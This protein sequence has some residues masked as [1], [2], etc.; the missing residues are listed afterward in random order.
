MAF[1]GTELSESATRKPAASTRAKSSGHIP[2]HAMKQLGCKACP[3]DKN[4]DKRTPKLDATGPRSTD[5]LVLWGQPSEA[6]DRNGDFGNGKAADAVI[7]Y[8][9][10]AGITKLRHFGTVRCRIPDGD[11]PGVQ[12][13]ECCRGY[14]IREIESSKPRVIVGVGDEALNWAIKFPKGNQTAPTFR[15]RAFPIKVGSH[16]CWFFVMEFPRY[17]HKKSSWKS[18]HE[19]ATEHDARAVR[20]LLDGDTLSVVHTGGYDKGIDIITGSDAGDMVRLEDALNWAIQQ[21]RVG[22]DYETNGLRP[23]YLKEPHIWTAA[24]G[25]FDRTIAFPI[26][27]PD[28]WGTEGRMRQVRGMF[29]EFLMQSGPKVAH[30]L[31]MEL[32]W[33]HYFWG[34]PVLW[35]T[36]WEDTLIQ[37]FILD[38]RE[39]TKGLG[40]QTLLRFGFDVKAQSN[41]DPVRLLEYPI[42]DALRYNGMDTKYTA[43]LFPLNAADI[44]A[45]GLEDVYERRRLLA[46]TLIA[47]QAKG[48]PVDIGY[49]EDYEKELNKLA[50]DVDDQVQRCP[51][52]KDYKQ[53]F[54]AFSPGNSHHVLKLMKDVL[55]RN[56][57][58]VEDRDGVVSWTTGEEVLSAMPVDEV[59]SAPLILKLRGIDKL[60][61]TNLEPITSGKVIATDGRIHTRF[62]STRAITSRLACAEPNLQNIPIRTPEGR[63][64][65][66]AFMALANQWI[67]ACDYGQI[68]AR[69]IGMASEDPNLMKYQWED[70]DIHGFWATRIVDEYPKVKDWIVRT[71]SVDWDE[72]GHKTLRQEAKNKWVFPQF[73]GASAHR[74]ASDLHLPE[75]VAETLTKEFWDEFKG[76]KKWQQKL[77]KFFE[78][79]LYVETL[80]GFRR[81]GPMSLNELINMPVQGSACTIVTA[82]MTELAQTSFAEADTEL[83]SNLNIHDDLT[84]WLSDATLMEKIERIAHIMC[85]PRF[86]WIT[87]PILVEVKIGARWNKLEE[88]A[89]Y[90]SDALYNLR[91][92]FK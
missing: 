50:R 38:G 66:G 83:Q 10:Q 22:V 88:V 6:D 45:Q 77:V 55:K 47:A 40:V 30:S 35:M 54:G 13:T 28:G 29:G 8:M 57:V 49:A 19:L 80:D 2:I 14:I 39:G 32:E 4:D 7:K 43:A 9:R 86:K 24:V 51:E 70:Y 60:V 73:F 34:D 33:S 17:V 85:R 48:V 59:P 62:S 46:S 52:V 58:R 26:D 90:R 65:R 3:Q 31:E 92:P 76:V 81:R 74:C 1:F 82:A 12:E 84:H 42:R 18:E 68:E 61:G 37:A 23:F 27:H 20:A 75:D 21:R 63:K 56:E 16:E 67:C 53:R 41:V 25:T 5:V 87:V 11:K 36:E 69:V 44:K 78:K 64:I 71:F 89:V 79:H 91:S 15:G 72:K